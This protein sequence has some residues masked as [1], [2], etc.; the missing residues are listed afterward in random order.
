LF[1]FSTANVGFGF[2]PILDSNDISTP[3]QAQLQP[4]NIA[5]SRPVSQA[6]VS[7]NVFFS[8]RPTQQQSRPAQ[9]PSRPTFFVPRQPVRPTNNGFSMPGMFNRFFG[10]FR[11]WSL[12]IILFWQ[13]WINY[14]FLRAL[15]I[16]TF[17]GHLLVDYLVS[18]H[19]CWK[20]ILARSLDH[21]IILFH[22]RSK[23]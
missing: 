3:T 16:L 20:E 22:F 18:I 6:T 1:E 9:F 11:G 12:K 5:S 2:R 17:L 21:I 13:D 15:N 19:N 4:V 7:N 8:S 23:R 14:Y 10:F